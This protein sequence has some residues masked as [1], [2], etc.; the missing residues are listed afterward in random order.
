M[1]NEFA[2][3]DSLGLYL[4]G[5]R[6]GWRAY[7]QEGSLGGIRLHKRVL[8]LAALMVGTTIPPVI[9]KHVSGKNGEGEGL[10]A[11]TD[12]DELTWTPP[13]GTVGSP[14]TV[15]DG[16]TKILEGDDGEK[17]VI[18]MRDG[19]M[20][21][22][23]V[24]PVTCL[25]QKNNVIGMWDLIVPQVDDPDRYRG[26]MFY[27]GSGVNDTSIKIK[28]NTLGSSV[29]SDVRQLGA[30]G[31]GQI[32][33][34]GTF[35]NWPSSG[36]ARIK[37]SGDSLREH[38]YYSERSLSMLTVFGFGRAMLGS[39]ASAG[40]NDDTLDPVPGIRI[41]LEAPIDGSIQTIVSENDAPL[42]ISWST[43]ITFADGLSIA[44]MVDKAE[45]GF[46]IDHE[47]PFESF[48]IQLTG[49][50]ALENS[51]SAQWVNSGVT[52]EE[53]YFGIYAGDQWTLDKFLV[54]VGEDAPP[55]ISGTPD[56]SGTSFPL[57]VDITPPGTGEKELNVIAL[58]QN[59]WG[60][61]SLNT[62]VHT[63]KIDDGGDETTSL[64]SVPE[65]VIA[66][67]RPGG[68]VDVSADYLTAP[69]YPDLADT[70]NLY[71][72]IDGTDPDPSV[73]TPVQEAMVH[74][75]YLNPNV[76][77]SKR[78]GPYL[79]ATDFRIVITVER[80][81]GG[82]ESNNTDVTSVSVLTIDPVIIEGRQGYLGVVRGQTLQ[83]FL[84][85]ITE[86]IDIPTNTRIVGTNG[87]S[88]FYIGNTLIWGIVAARDD[89]NFSRWYIPKDNFEFEE[90][91]ISGSG[92]SLP[93]QVV[94]ANTLYIVV[95][96]LRVAK[97]DVAA[98]RI[99]ASPMIFQVNIV[100]SFYDGPL[101]QRADMT[102]FQAWDVFTERWITG[103]TFES[104]GTMRS[105]LWVT[106]NETQVT[107]EGL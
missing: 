28:I 100:E 29:I 62:R 24:M 91:V 8:S 86:T 81:T 72:R 82:Q 49:A 32:V 20:D 11:A 17:F 2:G 30:S 76:T 41:G 25:K 89:N 70:W 79:Y 87:R 78:L 16:E 43:E 38:V 84:G 26:T 73:D 19:T 1:S 58:D 53:T 83:T 21:L 64:L 18:V 7:A 48:N 67:A 103:P 23:G 66:V 94:D 39:S 69:D 31:G 40:A 102:V 101:W 57:T 37:T 107:I 13:Y 74:Y 98:G 45:Y 104:D 47:V 75:Q 42:T 80:S 44:T 55:D 51:F 97:I 4:T 54:F 12:V 99:Q 105:N 61:R 5:S 10:I 65:N 14:V 33:T 85:G 93:V 36:W 90:T 77:F 96:G 68:Y 9:I 59:A 50:P 92:G 60:L 71:I 3:A 56:A 22:V 35:L 6:T 34:T 88:L 106:A 46:W 63:R 95:N 15:L 52:Y 27:N